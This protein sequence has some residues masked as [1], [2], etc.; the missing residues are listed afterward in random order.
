MKEKPKSRSFEDENETIAVNRAF[1]NAVLRLKLIPEV[2]VKKETAEI[3]QE[4]TNV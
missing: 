2:G 1:K 4:E 3:T